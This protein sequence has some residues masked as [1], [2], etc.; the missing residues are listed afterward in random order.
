MTS[1]GTPTIKAVL[2]DIDGTLIDTGGAGA[3]SWRWAFERLHGVPADIATSS[4]AGMTDPDVAI[5]TFEAV[6]GRAPSD[7]ELARLFAW[8]VYRLQ[9]EVA[10]SEGYRILGG[11]VET[12]GRLMDRGVV[13]GIVSGGLEGSAR[14]KLERGHLNRYFPVGAFGTDSRDRREITRVAIARVSMMHGRDIE[15]SDVIVVGDTPLDVDAANAV[16]AISLGVA[17]GTYAVD[18]LRRSGADFVL[19]SLEEP[20]PLTTDTD[21]P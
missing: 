21:E 6:L 15:A 5:R 8:Y 16:G 7:H 11:V 18:E 10:I 1:P 20:F 17:S 12:L 19:A 3:R 14:I 2:F 4:S 9:H 13:L